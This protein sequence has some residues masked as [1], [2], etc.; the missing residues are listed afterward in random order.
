[1]S[2]Y[3]TTGRYETREELE[4]SIIF[5]YENYYLKGTTVTITDISRWNGVST[6]V[7]ER[8]WKEHRQKLSVIHHGTE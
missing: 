2:R 7:V 5:D 3:P 1:M 4:N 6:G 8:I